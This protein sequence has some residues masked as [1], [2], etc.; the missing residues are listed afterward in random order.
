MSNRVTATAYLII[1]PVRRG[2]DGKVSGLDIDRIVKTKPTRLGV[3]DVA[4]QLNISVDERLFGVPNPVVDIK[5]DDIRALIVPEV[6][7]VSQTEPVEGQDDG[8]STS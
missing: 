7:V 4:I 3:R 6:E 5:L 2:Y 1:Q 8:E